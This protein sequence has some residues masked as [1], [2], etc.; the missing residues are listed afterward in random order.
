MSTWAC[1]RELS[2][3]GGGSEG[4]VKPVSVG[5]D[6]GLHHN[7]GGIICR[8]IPLFLFLITDFLCAGAPTAL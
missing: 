4:G 2:G 7:T 3:A 5:T 6:N 8:R 1:I